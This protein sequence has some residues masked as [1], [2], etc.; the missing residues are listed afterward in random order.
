MLSF[1][2]LYIEAIAT[3]AEMGGHIGTR[4]TKSSDSRTRQK[5][6]S[7]VTPETTEIRVGPIYGRKLSAKQIE[8][9]QHTAKQSS[10]QIEKD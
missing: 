7:R 2:E 8:I 6:D 5:P 9:E 3:V 1:L 10:K 4:L